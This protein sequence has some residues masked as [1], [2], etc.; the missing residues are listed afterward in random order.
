MQSDLLAGDAW[1]VDG[2]YGA[3]FDVRFAR[4]DTVI[5][6]APPRL[7]CLTR[8]LRRVLKQQ[9]LAVQAPGCPERLN[10]TFLKWVWRYPRDSRPRLDAALD[11]HRANLRV[12]ELTS[13][14]QGGKF[15]RDVGVGVG[16][17]SVRLAA[18]TRRHQPEDLGSAIVR[19]EK[20]I[21]TR[22]YT[23]C[24]SASSWV[25]RGSST[26]SI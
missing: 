22:S 13:S 9:G 23:G 20:K 4:A 15:L 10:L 14:A 1:T 17:G 26:A 8:A 3:T 11:R 25:A 21:G 18:R 12:I 7:R 5:V 24:C 6:L 16:I 2:N 19:A